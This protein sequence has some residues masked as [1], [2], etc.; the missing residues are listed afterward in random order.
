MPRGG[1][2]GGEGYFVLTTG[3]F[4]LNWAD[5]GENIRELFEEDEEAME[6]AEEGSEC[7]GL[8]LFCKLVGVCGELVFCVWG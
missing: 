7:D 1:L 8:M 2:G 3:V 5:D 6:D 4:A